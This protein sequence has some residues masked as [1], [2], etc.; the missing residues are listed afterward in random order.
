MVPND[1]KNVQL[2]VMKNLCRHIESQELRGKKRKWAK[3]N[4][5]FL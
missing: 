2:T 5:D 4:P 1:Y 3:L